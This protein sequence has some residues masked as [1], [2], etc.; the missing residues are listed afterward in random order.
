LQKKKEKK[1]IRCWALQSEAGGKL[2]VQV[3]RVGQELY[4]LLFKILFFQTG[5]RLVHSG[6][7]FVSAFGA[8]YTHNHQT[9]F[10]LSVTYLFEI[11]PGFSK[12]K[13][14][15][16]FETKSFFKLI[17]LTIFFVFYLFLLAKF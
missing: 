15:F 12:K 4:K 17:R 6:N 14:C 16:N 10:N 9:F 3:C 2:K 8:R 5:D 7:F 1:K 13:T 11:N